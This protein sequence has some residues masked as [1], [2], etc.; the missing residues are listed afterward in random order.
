MTL[1]KMLVIVVV[2][3]LLMLAGIFTIAGLVVSN[4]DKIAESVGEAAAHVEN[5]Y[6]KGKN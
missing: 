4:C 3:W 5:G 6:E 1:N 2:F